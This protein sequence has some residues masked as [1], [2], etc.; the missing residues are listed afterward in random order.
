M[1]Q[2]I[3]SLFKVAAHSAAIL[4]PVLLSSC[5]DNPAN[6]QKSESPTRIMSLDYCADQYVLK[7]AD[8]QHI[9]ALSPHATADF[10]YM[11]DSAVGLPT[12][13]PVAENILIMNPDLVVRTYG[14][15]PNVTAFLER[16]G[17][18]VLN[19][20][21][22]N[23]ID[24]VVINIERLSSALGSAEEGRATIADMRQ[25]L[26]RARLSEQSVTT[27]Y[28]T[29]AGVT[30]GPG[31]LVHELITA[32]G[33][34]NFQ[35]EPGWRSLPLERLAYE[36]PDLVAA[37]FFGTLTNHPDAWSPSNHPVAQAQMTNSD[38]VPIEGAWTA[39]GGWFLVDAVEALSEAAQ[40]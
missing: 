5:G 25:R 35:D 3:L 6:I 24:D 1:G 29:P 34:S 9:L 18:P 28:M 32:A 23:T 16:A 20:G 33:L 39:C 21:W 27:L 15:G 31:S 36:K 11:R 14:G 2:G 10:S 38:L 26:D 17:I 8:R 37:A 30:T 22:T 12:I 40:P 13:R 4:L 7:F 19:V